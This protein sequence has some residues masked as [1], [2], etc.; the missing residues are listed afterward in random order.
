MAYQLGI[1]LGTTYTAAAVYDG[2]SGRGPEVVGLGDRGPTVPSVLCLRPDGEF[3]AGDAAERHAVTDPQRIARQFKRRLGDPTPLFVGDAALPAEVLTSRLLRWVVEA[4]VRS[5]GG[6]RPSTIVLTHPANWGPFKRDLLDKASELAGIGRSILLTEPQAAAISYSSQSRVEAGAVI[7]VYDLGGGTFDAA[8]LR[9]ENDGGFTMLGTPEGIE[10]LGGIDVDAAV[11]AHVTAALG[12]AYEEL[13]P[14]DPAALAAV[15]RLRLDCTQ[16]KEALSQDTETT[17]PVLLPTIQ[18][19]V[20]VTRA[21]LEAMIR[22]PL[23]ETVT[24]LE[25][26]IRSAGLAADAIDH[27]LLVGGSSRIPLVAELVSARLGRP[28][29]V[30]AH[31]KHAIALGAAIVAARAAGALAPGATPAGRPAPMPANGRPAPPASTAAMAAG[32]APADRAAAAAMAAANGR[33]A[34]PASG[35]DARPAPPAPVTPPTS[36]NPGPPAYGTGPSG[37]GNAPAAG[38]PGAP[39]PGAPP[40]PGNPGPPAYGTA[41]GGPGTPATPGSQG[42]P[43]YGAPPAGP[44]PQGGPAAPAYGGA[45]SGAGNPSAPPPTGPA[46]G[47]GPGAPPPN[48]AYGARPGS[49]PPGPAYS[50]HSLDPT[51]EAA[52]SEPPP[53][54]LGYRAAG[55]PPPPGTSG[56]LP[57]GYLDTGA[58]ASRRRKERRKRRVMIALGFLL[59]LVAVGA[60]LIIQELQSQPETIASLDVG[61]CFNGEPTDL[62][63]VDCDQPHSGELY[64]L[65]PPPDPQAAYPGVEVL[66]NEVGQACITALV[67]Y[68]GAAAEVAAERGIEVQPLAPSED[69]WDDGTTD[70]YCVAVPAE[71]GTA[72]GSIQGRGAA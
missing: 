18:T 51:F 63:T 53:P 11:F 67:D 21:E 15:A 34:P 35:P 4:V 62:D 40:T 56:D 6:E 17:V 2:G 20:R 30:D 54:S 52:S 65:A 47:A 45:T 41:P 42:A 8:V 43:A 61:E 33:P 10:H 55:M 36:G 37:P 28:V 23:S 69:E 7:A 44:G 19:E 31:P 57:P 24:A 60:T 25:R 49:P 12:D 70:V 32:A 68:F 64:F 72:S 29:A 50:G 9:K 38:N 22:P 71:G 66:Q 39:P 26:A 48:Q 3:V 14:D 1:D 5:Q 16:A 46:Y 58:K 13:D 59:V 27:V